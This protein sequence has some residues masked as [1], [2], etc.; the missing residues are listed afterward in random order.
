MVR[1][2]LYSGGVHRLRHRQVRPA[3]ANAQR[4][5]CKGC[6]KP[7]AD[8]RGNTWHG[9]CWED[10]QGRANYRKVA[11][12]AEGKHQRCVD[13]GKV[14]GEYVTVDGRQQRVKVTRD[15]VKALASNGPHDWHAPRCQWH[16]QEKSTEDNARAKAWRDQTRG[17]TRR[18]RRSMSNT[19]RAG[20]SRKGARGGARKG[21]RKGARSRRADAALYLAALGVIGAAVVNIMGWWGIVR[22]ALVRAGWVALPYA[23]AGACAVI[24]GLALRWWW[25]RRSRA[26]AEAV[27]RLTDAIGKDTNTDPLKVRARVRQWSHGV[28]V[29]GEAHY[30]WHF[31]DKPGSDGRTKVEDTL[32]HKLGVRLLVEWDTTRDMVRWRPHPDPDASPTAQARPAAPGVDEPGRLEMVQVRVEDKV[33]A[34]VKTD[35]AA[36]RFQWGEA[37]AVGPLAFTVLYPSS[38]PDESP[39]QRQALVDGVNSKAPGRWKGTWNTEQNAVLFERRPPMP[40]MVR[41]PVRQ[42]RDTYRIPFGVD[43]GSKHQQAVWDMKISPHALVVGSTG[44]GKTITLRSMILAA[45]QVGFVVPSVDP[46]R[47]EL[48]GLRGHPGVPVVATDT[49]D[50]VVLVELMYEEMERRYAAVEAGEAREKDYEP[51]LFPIDELHD[52]IEK[53]QEFHEARGGRGQAPVIRKFRSMGRLGRKAR[54]HLLMGIQRP[55]ADIVGGAARA[56]IK[57]RVAM[58]PLDDSGARMM[59][60]RTDVGRDVPEDAKGRATAQLNNQYVEV[61]CYYTPDAWDADDLTEEDRQHLAALRRSAEAV[62]SSAL[63]WLT[64]ESLTEEAERRYPAAE[65]DDGTGIR[66]RSRRPQA[67]RKPAPVTRRRRAVEAGWDQIRAHELLEGDVVRL[68]VGDGDALL[69]VTI[70]APLDEAPDNE[71]MV[72]VPWRSPAGDTGVLEIEADTRVARRDQ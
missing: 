48:I 72:Q 52:W 28:P 15:H 68:P 70:D 3:Y 21:A 6:G 7:G 46:K 43:E 54:V 56:N 55:D 62:Q 1:C 44:S 53:V 20:A 49:R 34:L 39:D 58:G 2:R 18:D 29:A 59:Y 71:D 9:K 37:D 69:E 16:H 36:V 41:L 8:T 38:F 11:E 13:C 22:D 51:L 19:K 47:T 30:A 25:L 42:S 31:D 4:G 66:S 57:F 64:A 45:L 24:A 50:M 12:K 61:Q 5:N 14:D 35:K 23:I 26:R 65:D 27:M 10:Y 63:D 32:Q 60:G 67:R 33:R 17:A 40:E